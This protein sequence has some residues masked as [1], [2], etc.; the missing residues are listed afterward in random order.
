M[1]KRRQNY[2]HPRHSR[3]NSWTIKSYQDGGGSVSRCI[4]IVKYAVCLTGQLKCSIF[5]YLRKRASLVALTESLC[6]HMVAFA[7]I[8]R[9]H[10]GKH[11][12]AGYSEFNVA[13][14]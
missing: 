3:G 9:L 12:S 11:G 5:Y 13:A 4:H 10:I 1:G 2:C 14:S 8:P 7:E 6:N